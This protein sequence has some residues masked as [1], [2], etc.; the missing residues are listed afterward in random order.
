[1]DASHSFL[2][3]YP[4]NQPQTTQF[5]SLLLCLI[6]VTTPVAC[7]T[8]A[9]SPGGVPADPAAA[10]LPTQAVASLWTRTAGEDWPSFLGP[11]GDGTSVEKGVKP[12]LCNLIP[13]CCGNCR[14]A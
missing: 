13:S 12:E 1:M 6:A 2:R 14:W 3:A 8:K 10:K 4:M 11:R 5:A 9:T 7:Q